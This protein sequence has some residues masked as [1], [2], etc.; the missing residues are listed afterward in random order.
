MKSKTLSLLA[1]SLVGAWGFSFSA[2]ATPIEIQYQYSGFTAEFD[3]VTQSTGPFQMTIVTDTSDP[4]LG[5][6]FG[7]FSN[8]YAASVYITA[9]SLGLNNALITSP[10]YLY[11]GSTVT[12]WTDNINAGFGTIMSEFGTSLSFGSA[13]NLST[14]VVPQGPIA[15]SGNEFRTAD[16]ITF[17]NGSFFNAGQSL[18]LSGRNTLSVNSVA[19]PGPVVGAG[20]P[21][22]I[23]AFGGLLG[24]MRRRKAALAA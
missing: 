17:N 1:L 5:S 24:W 3:N 9:P 21:G 18:A 8:V 12:G 2:N 10:T 11:F 14:L 20:L 13:Y 6:G 7:S 23:L 16:A 22:A 4:N 19:V 15:E